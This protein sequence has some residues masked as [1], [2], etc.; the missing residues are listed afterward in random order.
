[1]PAKALRSKIVSWDPVDRECDNGFPSQAVAFHSLVLKDEM[2]LPP[3]EVSLPWETNGF[4]FEGIYSYLCPW[5]DLFLGDHPILPG[6]IRL[7]CDRVLRQVLSETHA[8]TQLLCGSQGDRHKWACLSRVT[9][10]T[11]LKWSL[12]LLF[13]SEMLLVLRHLR[14]EGLFPQPLY[15]GLAHLHL[16]ALLALLSFCSCLYSFLIMWIWLWLNGKVYMP[17]EFGRH[18]FNLRVQKN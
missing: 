11:Q 15:L 12:Y 9:V 6:L 16:K 4:W 8:Q 13:G 14:L 1:M 17:T 10:L 18:G 7:L 5:W 3:C 2:I